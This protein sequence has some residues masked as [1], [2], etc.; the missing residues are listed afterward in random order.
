MKRVLAGAQ[1]FTRVIGLIEAVVGSLL[2]GIIFVMMLLQITLRYVPAF[3]GVWVGEVARFALVW[4][5]F[6]LVGYLVSKGEHPVIETIDLVI[7]G[8]GRRW[9][10]IFV[11]VVIVV[12]S[13]AFAADAAALVGSISG[14]G[15]PVLRIPMTV[16]YVVP[17]IGFILS[18]IHALVRALTFLIFPESVEDAIANEEGQAIA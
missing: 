17:M 4:L 13:V 8:R 5:T 6:A 12:I 18:A 15:T 3:Q 9:V 1:R 7:K 2:V 16:I 10:L 14:Q 11:H